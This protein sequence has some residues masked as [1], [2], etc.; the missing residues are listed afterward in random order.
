METYQD[1]NKPAHK[2]KM[3]SFRSEYT[4]ES[5]ANALK[6]LEPVVFDLSVD[7]SSLGDQTDDLRYHH[8]EGINIT[9]G[10]PS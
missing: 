6:V 10:A 7:R 5:K 2:D 9:L 4:N 1:D 3:P 8:Q